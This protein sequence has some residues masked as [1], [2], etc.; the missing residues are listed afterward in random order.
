MPD[1]VLDEDFLGAGF[2][3]TWIIRPARITPIRSLRENSS[4][5]S[6]EIM[7]THLPAG[8]IRP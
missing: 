5:M 3:T 7:I 6:E 4:G 8:R 1:E 2:A